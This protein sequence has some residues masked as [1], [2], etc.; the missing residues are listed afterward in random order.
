MLVILTGESGSGKSTIAN[1]IEREQPSFSKIVTYTTRPIRKGE[2]NGRDYHFVSDQEFDS[3]AQKDLFVEQACYRDWKYG[4]PII[5]DFYENRVIILTPEGVRAL[6][7]YVSE[8][9]PNEER[10]ILVVYLWVDR[11]SRMKKLL[12]RGDD[13]DEA[14]R[15][16]LSEVIQ[17]DSFQEKDCIVTNEN[18]RKSSLQIYSEVMKLIEQK[19]RRDIS[20]HDCN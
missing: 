20:S 3:L 6:K 8:N 18:Y 9:A 11:V 5:R 12:E 14:Y 4:V 10:N 15:R 17:F 2:I 1:I 13:I 19:Q 16:N 7:K